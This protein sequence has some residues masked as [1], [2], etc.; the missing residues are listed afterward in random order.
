M[1]TQSCEC[2]EEWTSTN[3]KS[4]INDSMGTQLYECCEEWTST[5]GKSYM[6][7]SMGTQS[8]EC[9]EEWTSTKGK[10]ITTIVWVPSYIGV[11]GN[12]QALIE[13]HIK[14]SMGT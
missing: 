5:N 11:V 8:Y 12:E 9:Y 1:G 13:N 4:Y 3:G 7:D 10:L 2:C 14:D 6:N